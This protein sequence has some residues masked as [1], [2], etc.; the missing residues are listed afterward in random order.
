V[1]FHRRN[2]FFGTEETVRMDQSQWGTTPLYSVNVDTNYP[3]ATG[4]H[5][6]WSSFT[7]RYDVDNVPLDADVAEANAVAAVD[8]A[9]YM[10]QIYRSGQGF[11]FRTYH[12]ALPFVTGPLI[13]GVR[14]RQD[15]RI[16]EGWVTDITRGPDPAWPEVEEYAHGTLR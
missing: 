3:S 13:D 16:R 9:N 5:F 12:G 6:L 11:M 15:E 1:F 7:V 4:R 10:A 2:E 8:V 14:W